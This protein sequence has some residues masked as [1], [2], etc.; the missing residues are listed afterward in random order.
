MNEID[1]TNRGAM[2]MNHSEPSMPAGEPSLFR[3]VMEMF[4]G[5]LGWVS[6]L[7][8]V[9]TLAFA[10]FT[11]V[12]VVYFFRAE[13]EREMLAW[14]GGFALGLI[15]ISFGRLWFWLLLHR[16]AIMREIKRVEWQLAQLSSQLRN[17][18]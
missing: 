14:A 4:Q 11:V 8:L 6:F 9:G 18:K 16:N 1:R 10:V 5:S 12:T 3:Q 17:P 15:A 7:V 2:T 13:S